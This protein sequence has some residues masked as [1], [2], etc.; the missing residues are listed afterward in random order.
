[1]LNYNLQPLTKS[2]LQVLLG[3]LI[4]VLYLIQ[5]ILVYAIIAFYIS[6]LGRPIIGMLGKIPKI[7]YR[8]NMTLK[9]LS[10]C[11]C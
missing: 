9:P 7:G 4:Y 1:M 10:P 3:L 6:I 11:Y 8:L 2:I 5:G